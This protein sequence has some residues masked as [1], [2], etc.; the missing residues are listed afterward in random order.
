MYEKIIELI[1]NNQTIV[2]ISHSRPDADTIGS[3]LALYHFL[4]KMGK[5]VDYYC[6]DSLSYSLGYLKGSEVITSKIKKIIY[7]LAIMV[8]CADDTRCGEAGTQLFYSAKKQIAIDHH[9]KERRD[10]YSSDI[11]ALFDSKAAANCQ[12]VYLLLKEMNKE[13]NC[14]DEIIANCLYS[15][16]V[17]DTGGLS[18][19][20]VS[21]KTL[22]IVYELKRDYNVDSAE[23]YRNFMSNKPLRVFK[24]KNLVL[25]KAEFYEDG[26]VGIIVFRQDDFKQVGALVSDTEGIINEV[27]NII[28]VKIAA[29]ITELEDLDTCK[30]SL[31]SKP[32]YNVN[33]VASFHFGGGGH[34]NAAGCQAKGGIEE[35]KER[36]I[37]ACCDEF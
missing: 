11:I 16:I 20:N 1:K 21:D 15:G 7:D 22:Q 35:V 19:S 13:F 36:V 2:I 17:T 31:R 14:M 30:I 23:I 18:F 33:R 28:D 25:S 6:Q 10:C 29:A 27:V 3:G 37:K 9:E 8:D 4:K 12:I 26:K 34:I 24:L 5:D 32:G